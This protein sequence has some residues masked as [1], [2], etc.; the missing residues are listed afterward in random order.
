MASYK[1]NLWKIEDHL[2]AA[3]DQIK[4]IQ[5]SDHPD[6]SGDKLVALADKII[7]VRHMLADMIFKA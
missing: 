1:D 2:Q 7:E 4:E 3:V 6:G 5:L